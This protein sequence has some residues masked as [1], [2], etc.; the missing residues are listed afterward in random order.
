MAKEDGLRTQMNVTI[1]SSN[2]HTLKWNYEKA[3]EIS[4]D[5]IFYRRVV[6]YGKAMTNTFVLPRIYWNYPSLLI[7][8]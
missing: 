4:L 6:P 3:L 2:L 5:K 8:R 7:V 1:T